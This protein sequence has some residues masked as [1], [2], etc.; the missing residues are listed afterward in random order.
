MKMLIT[1]LFVLLGLTVSWDAN[2]EADLAGYKVYWGLSS[3]EYLDEKDLGNV[4]EISIDS[5]SND[6]NGIWFFAVTA[7]DTA[8]NES[9][10]SKEIWIDFNKNDWGYTTDGFPGEVKPIVE[11]FPNGNAYFDQADGSYH[12]NGMGDGNVFGFYVL[13][14]GNGIFIVSFFGELIGNGECVNK[15]RSLAVGDSVIQVDTVG[16]WFSSK[17][18]GN[19]V[20]INFFDD[21]WIPDVSDANI[22]IKNLVASKVVIENVKII[23]S[24][25][26][27]KWK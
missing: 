25:T 8:N 21:C 15:K 23:R 18:T 13:N 2:K 7:Y 19:K 27:I 11:F 22:R 24:G 10:Y 6:F 17:F 1:Y 4:T 3:R 26:V 12:I 5:L 20:L 16:T 9:S 14:P